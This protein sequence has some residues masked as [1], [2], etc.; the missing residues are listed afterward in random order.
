MFPIRI[1]GDLRVS[2]S[3]SSRDVATGI[4]YPEYKY[5]ANKMNEANKICIS[6]KYPLRGYFLV[7]LTHTTAWDLL[8]G[9]DVFKDC[10]YLTQ[11]CLA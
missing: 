8:W 2:I 3:I 4:I 5:Y 6:R 7:V 11:L 9:G 10:I 1:F